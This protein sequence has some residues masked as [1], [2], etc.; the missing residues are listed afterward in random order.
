M[1]IREIA[2]RFEPLLHHPE[3]GRSREELATGLRAHF[4]KNYMIYYTFTE[5]DLIIVHVV[6]GSRDAIA[7]FSGEPS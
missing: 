2:A 3:I 6:H 7:L 5:T 1:F 4:H